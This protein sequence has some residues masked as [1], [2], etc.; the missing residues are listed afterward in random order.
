[1]VIRRRGPYLTKVAFGHQ[2]LVANRAP[3]GAADCSSVGPSVEDG[4][5]YFHFA[6]PGITMFSYV[7]VEAQRAVVPAL[8][9]AV[10][11]QKVNGKNRCVSAVLAAKRQHPIFQIRE[12]GNGASSDRY[13]FGHP[14]EIG[15]A[16]R[17]RATGMAAPL[18]G[19]KV[20]EVCVPGDIDTRQGLAR[21]GEEGEDLRLVALK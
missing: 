13:D 20:G 4:A 6:G 1:M 15:V 8:A 2:T 5:Y 10:L 21:L 18:I 9:H 14:A 11:L 17:D 12:R 19:L 7:A 16:H 3:E